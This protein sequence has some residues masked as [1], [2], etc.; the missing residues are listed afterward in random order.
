M[1][2]KDGSLFH[3]DFGKVLGDCKL[4]EKILGSTKLFASL[5]E[6]I[7]GINRDRAPF[8]FTKSFAYVIDPTCTEKY[9]KSQKLQEFAQLCC[10]A[11]NALRKE[12]IASQRQ[13]I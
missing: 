8:V 7:G 12:V 6:K 5:G 10:E 2:R 11:Y 1:I 4:S 3:V 9:E 13:L